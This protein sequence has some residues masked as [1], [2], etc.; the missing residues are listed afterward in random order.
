MRS[1]IERIPSLDGLRAISISLVL[2]SHYGRDVGWREPFD[3]GSLGVRIFF[4]I[5]GY[6][7]TGLLT[8]E[9]EKHGGVNLPRFYFRRTLRIFPAFYFYVACMLVL[10]GFGLANLTW[11]QALIALTYT[12]NYFQAQLPF[13]VVHSWSLATEEQFY[14]IWPAVLSI[15]GRRR[16]IAALLALLIAAP[17]SSHILGARVGHAVPAFFNGPIGIGCLLA[18][19]RNTLH[20]V[21]PYRL[22]VHSQFG[23][24]LPLLIVIWSIFAYRTT[25]L[26]DEILSLLTNVTVALWLDW[27]VT[28]TTGIAFRGLNNRWVV[29]VGVLSYSLYLWQ[30]PFLSL[31]HSHPALLLS[32]PWQSLSRIIPRFSMIAI[33]TLTSYYLVERPMLSLRTWLEPKMFSKRSR[34]ALTGPSLGMPLIAEDT[35][36]KAPGMGI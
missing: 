4:I 24:L 22:W 11:H 26:R 36:A 20:R 9:M 34:K 13:T 5:S 21:K 16:G 8:N 18:L 12:S 27:S 33:C 17:L 14:L 35:G 10:S 15:S 6:L 30:Q 31:L 28:R 23:L 29:Y 3:F 32:G 1:N 2:I 25:G 19:L 7:I